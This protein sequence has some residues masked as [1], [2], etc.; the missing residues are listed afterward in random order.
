MAVNLSHILFSLVCYC[1]GRFTATGSF[2][3]E[4]VSGGQYPVQVQASSGPNQ[5]ASADVTVKVTDAKDPPQFSAAEF[6][7]VIN[8]QTS[9][10]STISLRKPDG[11]GGLVIS[12]EDT[13]K[14]QFDCTIENIQTIDIVDH[15]RVTNDNGECKLITQRSFNHFDTPKFTFEVRATD[16]NYRNMYA[17]AKVEV[18]IQ[19]TNNHAPQFSQKSYWAS[20]SSNFPVRNSILKVIATDKDAGS[21]GEITYELLD[22]EDR[23]R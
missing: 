23:S 8:E 19:D 20:V 13:S 9:S 6:S 15:F 7:V 16:K 5:V 11:S 4:L 18:I 2:D 12:D 1:I 14:S 17:S 10:G 21:F 3:Y 22:S